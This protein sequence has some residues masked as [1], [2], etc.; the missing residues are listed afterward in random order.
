MTFGLLSCWIVS[1]FFRTLFVFYLN[2]LLLFLFSRLGY[3]FES[4]YFWNVWI[5]FDCLF[6]FYFEFLF[7][8]SHLVGFLFFICI[9]LKGYTLCHRP[10]LSRRGLS[11]GGFV[12]LAQLLC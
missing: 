8:F 6:F 11:G 2:Y 12:V 7:S 9:Y 3:F 1:S 4:M 5:L 10:P